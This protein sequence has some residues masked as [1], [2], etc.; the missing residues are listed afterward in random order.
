LRAGASEKELETVNQLQ[1][2][3]ARIDKESAAIVTAIKA[4]A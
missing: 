3:K 2:E 1:A 4:G